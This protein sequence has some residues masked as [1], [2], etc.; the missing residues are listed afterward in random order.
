MFEKTLPLLLFALGILLKRIKILKQE[1]GQALSRLLMNIIIPT[2]VFGAISSVQIKPEFLLLP[3]VAIIIN[4]LLLLAAYGL[5][6][7]FNLQTRTRNAFLI[8]FP[9]LEGTIGYAV[10]MAAYGLNGL[11]VIIS[12]DLGNAIFLF[13]VVSFLA[14]ALAPQCG[15]ERFDIFAA[16]KRFVATPIVWAFALGI[17]TNM[18]HI[19]IPPM[20]TQLRT[21]ISQSFLFIVM[22]LLAAEFEL[23]RMP[24]TLSALTIYLKTG[25][26]IVLGVLISSIF[27]F[28]GIERIGIV[29]AASLPPSLLSVVFAKD[30]DLDASFL[31]S[32]CSIALPVGILACSLIAL[33]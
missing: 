26:G 30:N 9:T 15:G 13:S 28:G 7:L 16:L 21:D 24:F 1:D 31:A 32:L 4:T 10:M 19:Q 3:I 25:I 27:G 2:T 6:T 17:L 5:A 33:I 11:S 23:T 14:S 20:I 18:F 29:V 8:A 22:L 12:Y